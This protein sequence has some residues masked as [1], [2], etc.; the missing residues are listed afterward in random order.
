MFTVIFV[1][2]ETV[3]IV[4]NRESYSWFID[5]VATCP[6]SYFLRYFRQIT[7]RLA[8]GQM[9]RWM[10]RHLISYIKLKPIITNRNHT[11]C[12]LTFTIQHQCQKLGQ[13]KLY[14]SYIQHLDSLDHCLYTTTETKLAFDLKCCS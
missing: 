13:T 8:D 2:L 12:C 6:V 14:I 9:H 7:A 10:D 3:C 11:F 1:V 5:L 4:V